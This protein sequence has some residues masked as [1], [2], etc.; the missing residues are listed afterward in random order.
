MY[1]PPWGAMWTNDLFAIFG[2][3]LARDVSALVTALLVVIGALMLMYASGRV[4]GKRAWW[5]RSAR[6]MVRYRTP[7]TK[8]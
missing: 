6:T 4:S 2:I 3:E 1:G 7:T 8:L 5:D